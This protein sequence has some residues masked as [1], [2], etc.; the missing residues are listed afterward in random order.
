[1]PGESDTAEKSH[2]VVICDRAERKTLYGMKRVDRKAEFTVHG[3]FK[4]RWSGVMRNIITGQILLIVC[5]VFYLIWWYRGFRPGASVNRVGGLNGVL[6]LITAAAGF[7]GITFSLLPVEEKSLSGKL[8]P[9]HILIGG[10][11][12][13][14]MLLLA[15]KLIWNRVVTMELLLIVGWATLEITVIN[16]LNAIGILSDGRFLMMCFVT[17]IAFIISM[18]LYVAYYQMEEMKAF[19]AAMVPLITEAASMAILIVA[20]LI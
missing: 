10:I 5:C 1:M 14:I 19:Y 17:G 18:I 3:Y 4:E 13:Y 6:L 20:A 11:A 12:A 8:N 7:A 9:F 15:T 2:Q 16:R